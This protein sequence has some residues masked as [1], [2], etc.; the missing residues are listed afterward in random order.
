MMYIGVYLQNSKKLFLQILE[1]N[2]ARSQM[3]K[4]APAFEY[5]PR[6]QIQKLMYTCA[7]HFFFFSCPFVF[8]RAAPAAYGGS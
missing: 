7:T 3:E 6:D 5:L 8:F 1:K 4:P 2:M